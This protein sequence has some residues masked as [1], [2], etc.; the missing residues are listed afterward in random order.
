MGNSAF[1]DDGPEHSG[2]LV[3][4]AQH[5]DMQNTV[6]QVGK[7]LIKAPDT[8]YIDR[9]EVVA[10]SAVPNDVTCSE[11]LKPYFS[12]A[13]GD[14]F[15]P[16]SQQTYATWPV[17][18]IMLGSDMSIMGA[19]AASS[20]VFCSQNQLSLSGTITAAGRGCNPGTG[21]GNSTISG[22]PGGG[23]GYGNYGGDGVDAFEENSGGSPYG[24]ANNPAR[25][26]SGGA[27]VAHGGL[28]L[29][30]SLSLY[31]SI[32]LSV[33][34]S[35]YLSIFSSL[36]FCPLFQL[37]KTNQATTTTTTTNNSYKKNTCENV[38]HGGFE[39]CMRP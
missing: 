30:F 19:F 4:D 21:L 25:L 33:Y 38:S 34:L 18:L 26:G 3:I 10:D 36:F 28:S 12:C 20:M 31:L 13:S 9:T 35:I 27:P 37:N 6:I 2:V 39:R 1:I 7:L 23:A 15:P 5:L 14:F 11:S 32:C 8:F 29:S 24:N 22:G 17:S 16:D